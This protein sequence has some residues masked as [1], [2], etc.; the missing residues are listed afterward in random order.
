MYLGW[1]IPHIASKCLSMR[2]QEKTPKNHSLTQFLDVCCG[3]KRECS[4]PLMRW[5]GTCPNQQSCRA[6]R[7]QPVHH[8][9]NTVMQLLA[10]GTGPFSLDQQ[11]PFPQCPACLPLPLLY[12]YSSHLFSF[13]G[14]KQPKP[15]RFLTLIQLS[16]LTANPAVPQGKAGKAG[17]SAAS[18]AILGCNEN[19]TVSADSHSQPFVA[20]RMAAKKGFH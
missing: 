17:C 6:G 15:K 12:P 11:P 19:Q 16:Q 1:I 3:I 13:A 9:H 20:H 14:E 18:A 2:T 7:F 10:K 4:G 8:P 5:V